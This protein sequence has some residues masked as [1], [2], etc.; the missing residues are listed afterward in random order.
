MHKK[1]GKIVLKSGK[2]QGIFIGLV[3]GNPWPT[4]CFCSGVAFQASR[5][6]FPLQCYHHFLRQHLITNRP[7]FPSSCIGYPLHPQM[8]F[9]TQNKRFNRF[10]HLH[11]KFVSSLAICPTS[12][13]DRHS[14]HLWEQW[15]GDVISWE[16]CQQKTQH[17][18]LSLRWCS[19]GDRLR[20]TIIF[21][22]ENTT[23][24]L[25]GC[26]YL[27]RA[28]VTFLLTKLSAWCTWNLKLVPGATICVA[29]TFCSRLPFEG[30]ALHK[31]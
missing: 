7:K 14:N 6:L 31:C 10:S 12:L 13:L 1:S 8:P 11:D 2:Y 25:L 16:G 22:D 18:F 26:G 4:S 29:G 15:H 9:G 21:P 17:N 5:H 30:S 24:P 3:G 28:F 27:G 19:A 20:F 23:L